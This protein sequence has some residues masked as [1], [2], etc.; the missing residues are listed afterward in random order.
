LFAKNAKTLIAPDKITA[1]I[2]I[3]PLDKLAY[4]RE[5]LRN[6]LHQLVLREFVKQEDAGLT[7]A[8]LARRIGRKPEQVPGATSRP[9]SSRI[10]TSVSGIS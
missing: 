8:E 10:R 6:R 9:S 5:R 4:F 1:T 2:I 7:R 3:I